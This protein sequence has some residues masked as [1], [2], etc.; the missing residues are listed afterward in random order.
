M[1][2]NFESAPLLDVPSSHTTV[3][4]S[5]IDSSGRL[6]HVPTKLFFEPHIDGFDFWEAPTY[7]FLIEH[8]HSGEKLLFDLGLP[9]D[10]ENYPPAVQKAVEG[11]R[12]SAERDVRD[13]LIENGVN[14]DEIKDIIWSHHHFDHTG[15]PSVFPPST[16]LVVGPGLRKMVGEGYP[17][18]N[19]S[20]CLSSAWK[21]RNCHELDFESDKRVIQIGRWKALDWFSDG[22]FY[23]LRSEG[24]TLDHISGF[25]RTKL[26]AQSK[27]GKDEFILMGGDVAHHGGEFKPN[28][29]SPI[30]TTISPDP[31]LAPYSGGFCPG[32][33]YAQYNKRHDGDDRWR[34]PFL[35][36]AEAFTDDPEKAAWS[37]DVVGEFD[38]HNN[39]FVIFSHDATLLDVVEFYP[40]DATD[41]EVKGWKREGRWRFL[42]DLKDQ[43]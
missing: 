23:L 5:I 28:R 39:V 11:W 12:L 1:A 40:K 18:D 38:A 25:A 34:S 15:D 20:V 17:I 30:P 37:L 13:V 35:K 4:V 33:Y 26:R 36:T 21:N 22:S 9:K 16:N 8:G 2:S 14:L 3:K 29:F 24:H 41:W 19:E 27:T 31:R 7:S 32:E 43:S 6:A 10:P 42:E